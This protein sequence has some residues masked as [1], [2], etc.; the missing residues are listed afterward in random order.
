MGRRRSSQASLRA[1]PLVVL[2]FVSTSSMAGDGSVPEYVLK[3]GFLYNFAK[4]V[5]WPAGAF[6]DAEAPISIGIVGNDPFGGEL[7]TTLENKT[8]GGRSFSFHRFPLPAD[9]ERCH[10]LFVPRSE[11]ELVP[12]ILRRVDAWPVLTV[13]EADGFSRLGGTT[14]ILIEGERPRLEVNPE[15]AEHARLT[16]DA[17]LLR[18]ARIVRTESER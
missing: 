5:A 8:V 15:A 12:E 3:A 1:L 9:I 11:R 7:E 6:Q 2:V 16:I 14:N 4:Y 18:L 10:I 17:K 13:G